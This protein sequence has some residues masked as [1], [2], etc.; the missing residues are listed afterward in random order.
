MRKI[1]FANDEYFHIFNRGSNKQDIF[2]EEEDFWKFFDGLRDL[3]NTTCYEDRLNALGL[4]VHS[5]NSLGKLEFQGLRSFLS[6]KEKVVEIISYSF[7]PNHFHLIIKQLCDKGISYLM[8]KLG[9]SYTL[10][11]NKK[12]NRSGHIF[13][14]PFKAIHI[15]SNDYLL[16]LMGYVNG[17]IEI[18]NL[19]QADNYNWSSYRALCKW[20]G[21]FQSSSSASLSPLSVLGGLDVISEQFKTVADF[22]DM[23]KTVVRESRAKKEM[24]NYLL[25]KI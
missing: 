14:G 21:H 4:S 20:L 15:D 22:Q 23:V 9:G 24:K 6:E 7:S 2:L 10:Y 5:R 19:A 16:W 8:H 12:H 25:E 3:N 17:N 11:F 13:Q 18:H 1:I